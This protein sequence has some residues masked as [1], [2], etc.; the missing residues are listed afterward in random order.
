M[1][2][3]VPTLTGFVIASQMI[4][5]I[6]HFDCEWE[7]GPKWPKLGFNRIR[8][9]AN[10]SCGNIHKSNSGHKSMPLQLLRQYKMLYGWMLHFNHVSIKKLC[11]L[12]TW[13]LLRKTMRTTQ[14]KEGLRRAMSRNFWFFLSFA[15]YCI[16][17]YVYEDTYS[18]IFCNFL[19]STKTTSM[20]NPC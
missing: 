7:G 11:L 12:D 13:F 19:R 4:I 5:I 9:M 17:I 3:E 10:L 14:I 20:K 15:L 16:Y 1:D 2:P 18:W 8:N 6:H